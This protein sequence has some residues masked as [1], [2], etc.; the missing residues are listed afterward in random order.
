MRS[1]P[2]HESRHLTEEEL[3][4][5][6]AACPAC[7]ST[8]PRRSAHAIQRDPDIDLLICGACGIGSASWMP[9]PE[10][11]ERYYGQYY[12]DTEGAHVTFSGVSRLSRRIADELGSLFGRPVARVVDFGGGDGSVSIGIAELLVAERGV[13]RVDIELVDHAEPADPPRQEIRI[14]RTGDLA[15]LTGRFDIVIASAI[16]EHVPDLH[17]TMTRLFSLAGPG[18]IFYARTPWWAPLVG[19]VPGVDLTFPGHVH[20]IGAPFWGG[21]VETY[22]LDAELIASR[23]SIVETEWADAPGRTLAASL[24]K[25]P[26][27]LEMLLRGPRTRRPV[28]RWVGGWE[29]VVACAGELGDAPAAPGRDETG[30]G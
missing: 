1:T 22:G 8:A 10:T 2:F 23:P 30:S 25:S 24:L 14:Q 27:R 20:D 18:A 26:S 6:R 11:L 4:D 15:D 3:V 7:L 29:A 5:A 19:V 13:G 16:L 12:D 28:W 9:T 17:G 21:V